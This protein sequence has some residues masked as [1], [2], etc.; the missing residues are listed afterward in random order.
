MNWP[1]LTDPTIKINAKFK[2]SVDDFLVVEIP[3]Y[4]PC[5]SGE[6]LYILVEKSGLTTD[7]LVQKFSRLLHIKA[8]HIGYA[9]K[10]D[11]IGTTQQWL[12]LWKIK[13]EQLADIQIPNVHVL[14]KEYHR[15]KLRSG[16][17][18]GN[19][20]SIKLK[21][22]QAGAE[23]I[24]FDILNILTKKGVPNYFGPQRFG[25]K[26]DNPAIGLAILHDNW[27]F[28]FKLILGNPKQTKDS[29]TIFQARQHFEEG[30]FQEA[31][32]LWP[33]DQSFPQTALRLLIE[34]DGDFQKAG[35]QLPKYQI[36]FYLNSLQS[37]WFN[38]TLAKRIFEFDV[39]WKGDLAYLHRN[40]AV[41]RVVDPETE[42]SR[43]DNFEISP[44]GPLWGKKMILPENNEFELEHKI[45]QQ[46]RFEIDKLKQLFGI[47]R[48]IG[49]RRSYRVPLND[50]SVAQTESELLLKFCLPT[51]SYATSVVREI[52]KENLFEPKIRKSD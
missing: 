19:K 10:K 31:L 44:S 50:Y 20:F 38:E 25:V 43:V 32:Y 17:L 2:S 42:Q 29:I 13:K 16:H 15:N 40:G 3:L 22:V 36:T 18:K 52:L 39:I 30:N 4:F 24:A 45:L 34:S 47:W 26:G 1:Y 28:V 23:K 6:H 35:K 46:N 41:F 8:Q 48:I 12:S 49:G 21:N 7:Q 37:L 11:R 14:E 27:P 33:K 51:G 9:G 5:G